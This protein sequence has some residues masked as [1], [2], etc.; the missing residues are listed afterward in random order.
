MF[1]RWDPRKAATNLQKH[2][3]DFHEAATVFDDIL[4]MTFPDAEHSAAEDRSITLGAS[5]KGRILVVIH[6]DRKESVRTIS[7]RPATPHERHYYEQ[8]EGK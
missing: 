1:Y 6:A 5:A 2:R 7:A 3:V 8:R 4:S